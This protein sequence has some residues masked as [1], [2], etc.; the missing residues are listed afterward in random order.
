MLRMPAKKKNGDQGAGKK[1]PNRVGRAVTLWLSA[2]VFA[3]LE[4]WR[5]RQTVPPVRTDIIEKAIVQFLSRQ[6][7]E[8]PDPDDK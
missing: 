2:D 6:G 5:R 3:A 7:I 1:K 8:L 4:E